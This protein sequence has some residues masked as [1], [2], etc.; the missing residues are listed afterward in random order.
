MVIEG[1]NGWGDDHHLSDYGSSV[2]VN[3]LRKQLPFK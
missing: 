2:F 1:L 3:K